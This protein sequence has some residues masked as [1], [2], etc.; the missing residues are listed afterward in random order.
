METIGPSVRDRALARFFRALASAALE[1][2]NDLEA[3]DR[4]DQVWLTLDHAHLGSLQLQVAE[5]P[6]MNSDAGTSPREITQ[7]L[8]RGDEPNIR[9][10]L[11]AMAKRGVAELVPGVTPQRWR[12]TASYRHPT[13]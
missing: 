1:L 8:D 2:A 13:A 5:A 10:A 3:E 11:A 12:L 4:D 7:H 6:G 9:T